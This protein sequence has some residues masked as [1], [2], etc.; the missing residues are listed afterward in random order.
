MLIWFGFQTER[1]SHSSGCLCDNSIL[2]FGT[3][4]WRLSKFWWILD[5]K[6][7]SLRSTY[8]SIGACLNV[9]TSTSAEYR[10]GKNSVLQVRLIRIK[11]EKSVILL[12]MIEL[13]LAIKRL[14]CG[15]R[16]VT[17]GRAMKALCEMSSLSRACNSDNSSGNLLIWL[18]LKFNSEKL[19]K[20]TALKSKFALSKN[21]TK[22]KKKK[23]NSCLTCDEW[24]LDGKFWRYF[25][26]DITRKIATF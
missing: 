17:L 10:G 16:K 21:D 2:N 9:S 6:G 14:S 4:S 5:G 1:S 20:K 7:F 22:T 19:K 12:P 23:K 3:R 8:S 25:R 11:Q 13:L 18:L 26:Y 15:I 24:K